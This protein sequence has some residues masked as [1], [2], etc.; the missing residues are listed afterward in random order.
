MK[1]IIFKTLMLKGE[2]G[3]TLV[4]MEKTGHAGTTDTY[5]ITFDDGSTTDIHVEN[6]SSVE[7]IELT[8]QTDTEDTYTATLAD[9]STQSFSVLNH[10]ADI[11]A[12]SEELAA[13]L[14]MITEALEDQSALLNAR[15]DTFTSLPS[16]STAGDAELAD[17]RVGVDGKIYGSAGSA[18]RGQITGVNA[19]ISDI[20]THTINLFD[21][22]A[23]G[24][25]D[26]YTM[27]SNGSEGTNADAFITDFID[28]TN[29]SSIF[30]Y[31][32]QDIY[33]RAVLYN[34][35][36]ASDIE[37]VTTIADYHRISNPNNAPYLR[38]AANIHQKENL[39]VS[40]EETSAYVPYGYEK[41]ATKKEFA[42]AEQDL[43]DLKDIVG[44]KYETFG[45]EID[46][47]DYASTAT[48]A[49][50]RFSAKKSGNAGYLKKISLKVS[51]S[52]LAKIY[53]GTY[54]GTKYTYLGSFDISLSSGVNTLINGVDFNYPD[55]LPAN[56][57]IGLGSSAV[58]LYYLSGET[59]LSITSSS[60][61]ETVTANTNAYG[62]SINAE[63]ALKTDLDE[64]EQD[65]LD[66]QTPKDVF[67]QAKIASFTDDSLL[68]NALTA[69]KKNLNLA[70]FG[71]VSAFNDLEIGFKG[72]STKYD[73]III[74]DLDVVVAN[75]NSANV[76]T[77]QH[78]L[79]I[80]NNIAVLIEMKIDETADVTIMSN[81]EIWKQ[82]VSWYRMISVVS[83]YAEVSS[84]TALTDCIM[85][86]NCA[87]YNKRVFAY[88][89]SYFNYAPERWIYYA[90]EYGFVD[91]MLL[92]AYAGEASAAAVSALAEDIKH[93]KPKYILWTL[94]MNDS[95]DSTSYAANWKAGIDAVLEY[96]EQIHAVPVLATVP[97][98]AT[99]GTVTRNNE[100]KNE[101]IRSSGYRY[102]DFAKA[103]GAGA[104][105]VWYDG[106]LEPIGSGVTERV[107]PTE[108][109]A[110]ALFMQACVDFPEMMVTN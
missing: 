50:V 7:S 68:I 64:I 13:G 12:I 46:F 17:I 1:D 67:L 30:L 11:E 75:V 57:V 35:K 49:T 100:K 59:S 108:K 72:N 107:H 16:G 48:N 65:I 56:T 34:S 40:A 97:T 103:V 94:G 29:I 80:E 89:D 63:I 22:S 104:D 2:A 76:H 4:S 31:P 62:V 27:Y 32:E 88:G 81:G 43:S 42:Q 98:V 60:A 51:G 109:G 69:I 26:G 86:M 77:Y 33:A 61:V 92:D 84:S 25:K 90:N 110:K 37:S 47:S 52:G 14:S 95:S 83:P 66:L 8:S 85:T 96:C 39:C 58:S 87:D 93:G 101:W 20:G 24:I 78:G 45:T 38:I 71:T 73:R 5:T 105:G 10:N 54:I 44:T 79:T 3:S 18:V 91:N 9:G 28:V 99:N 74:S 55:E 19:D 70:F 15:M 82:N 53:I 41:C 6:L 23:N 21:L 36:D 102:I 106:M